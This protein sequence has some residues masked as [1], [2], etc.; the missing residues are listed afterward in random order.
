MTH[1]IDLTEFGGVYKENVDRKSPR[2]IKTPLRLRR[3]PDESGV[4]DRGGFGAQGLRG[5]D[6]DGRWQVVVLSDTGDDAGRVDG[7][8]FALD[9]VDERS[10]RCAE[11]EWCRGGVF[12]FDTDL[13]GASRGFSKCSER[14]VENALCCPRTIATER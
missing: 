1:L 5:A 6:A 14:E 3:I 9:R 2:D 8:Y 7:R 11:G 13:E 12:E 10:G 4:G